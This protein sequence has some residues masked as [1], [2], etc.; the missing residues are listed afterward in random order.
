[1]SEDLK[2]IVRRGVESW[3]TGDLAIADEIFAKD[4]VNH[5]PFD[6]NVRDLES[7]KKFIAECLTGSQT[8]M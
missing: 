5:Y 3:N 2:A 4:F 1:M 6:P 8:S 7:Y